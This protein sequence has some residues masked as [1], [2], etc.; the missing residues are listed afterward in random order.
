MDHLDAPVLLRFARQAMA[1][2]FEVILPFATPS[3][4]VFAQAALDEIDRLESQL[5]VYRDT[6]EVSAINRLAHAQPMRVERNLFDL[7]SRCQTLHADT[8]G[9]FDPA[10]GALIKTWGFHRRQGKVPTPVQLAFAL[11]R[12][13]MRHVELDAQRGTVRFT[14]PGVELNFGSVGKGYALDEALRSLREI[15][16]VEHL[17]MHGGHSSVVAVGNENTER[18]GWAVGLTDPLQP[19]RR[20]AVVHLRDRAL[21]TSAA[22]YQNLTHEGRRLGHLL[23]PRTGWPAEGTLSATV[24]APTAAEADALA[25]AFFILGAEKSRAYCEKRPEI[26]AVLIEAKVPQKLVVM[27]AARGEVAAQ[28]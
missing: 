22:T 20:R 14:Q 13:G 23:D 25:T 9:A 12:S 18:N 5:T 11:S 3:A 24:T 16:P 19:R 28:W 1:T 21:A 15:G 17:L 7:L 6:S 2:T 10:V 4:H 26:G 27:G 8:D